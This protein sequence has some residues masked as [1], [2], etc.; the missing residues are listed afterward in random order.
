MLSSPGEL[1]ANFPDEEIYM[2]AQALKAIPQ[3]L[4]SRIRNDID[5]MLV[6]CDNS[7]TSAEK[8]WWKSVRKQVG[9]T[10]A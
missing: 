5:L 7:L 8:K 4:Q 3:I 1:A 2:T 6:S 10:R 9:H